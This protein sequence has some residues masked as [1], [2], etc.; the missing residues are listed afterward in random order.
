VEVL[1][2]AR[3]CFIMCGVMYGMRERQRKGKHKNEKRE[4]KERMSERKKKSGS[5]REVNEG[6][7]SGRIL[8]INRMLRVQKR[9]LHQS[10]MHRTPPTPTHLNTP[11]PTLP[12]HLQIPLLILINIPSKPSLRP[13]TSRR[14]RIPRRLLALPP[15]KRRL[16][17]EIQSE[18]CTLASEETSRDFPGRSVER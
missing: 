1:P 8:G 14:I 13:R 11:I 18:A 7:Y 16:E 10:L 6:I 3:R 17:V 15:L 4:M 12:L 2:H 9:R 5:R